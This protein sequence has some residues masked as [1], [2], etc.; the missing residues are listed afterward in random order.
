[1]RVKG[2]C[3]NVCEYMTNV[4]ILVRGLLYACERYVYIR[5]E[6]AYGGCVYACDAFAY[7]WSMFIC[8]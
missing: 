7:V 1:M 5:M 4:Y 8:V 3:M 6:G 2:L